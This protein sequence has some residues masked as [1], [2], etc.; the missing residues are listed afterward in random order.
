MP[1]TE[2]PRAQID[3]CLNQQ[4]RALDLINDLCGTARATPVL[5]GNKWRIVVEKAESPVQMFTMGNIVQGTF[6]IS[7]RSEKEKFNT[8]DVTYINRDRNFDTDSVEV[9]SRH[10]VEELGKP[11]RRQSLSLFGVTR[12]TQAIREGRFSLNKSH[13]LRR[14]IQFE[15]STD[16]VLLQAG[17]VFLFQHELPQWGFG[18]R[19]VAGD[20]SASVI[21]LD[22]FVTIESGKTYELRIRYADGTEESG[23]V[24]TVAD[25][26][27]EYHALS[28][29]VPFSKVPQDGDLYAFGEVNISSKP[30]R[31]VSISR[32][33]MSKRRITAVE[34][35]ESVLDDS[36]D[37]VV[38]TY[39]QLPNFT[40][41]PPPIT[42]LS[43]YEEVAEQA[44][45]SFVSTI[46]L[47]WSS[48]LPISGAGMYRDALVE[49]SWNGTTWEP[50]GHAVGES[51]WVNAPQVVVPYFSVTPRSKLG[52]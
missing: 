44:D 49:R 50:L 36:G 33:G 24:R 14:L 31:C 12:R 52:V 34:Y 3:I 30:F 18:G 48:P 16:S 23:E 19:V 26:A 10:E 35:N 42:G 1:L 38:I 8:Y 21:F 46:I 13:Y 6:N 2:E 40:A 17:D 45:G 4:R 41:P 32:N 20:N 28:V 15:A 51:R 11:T 9:A 29:T 25:G 43:G 39:S 7:Y 27:G 5:S 37:I 47:Q 22:Q